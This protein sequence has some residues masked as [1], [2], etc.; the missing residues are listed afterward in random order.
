MSDIQEYKFFGELGY[1]LAET[2]VGMQQNMNREQKYKIYT[3]TG[4]DSIMKLALPDH[5]IEYHI[6]DSIDEQRSGWFSPTGSK[7]DMRELYSIA[8]N[9]NDIFNKVHKYISKPL[10][11]SNDYLTELTRSYDKI[12]MVFLRDRNWETYRNY[13]N[14]YEIVLN[15]HKKTLLVFSNTIE[16]IVP[17][18]PG[19]TE[20]YKTKSLLENIYFFNICDVFISSNSGMITLAQNSACK[21][22]LCLFDQ[23]HVHYTFNPF[24]TV[25]GVYSTDKLADIINE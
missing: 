25:I 20:T 19:N 3:F 8:G 2:L 4:F 7:Y 21:K 5:N 13:D 10:T 6:V 9:V 12:I 18:A 17:T 16:S 15:T 11:Y 23:E 14:K 22:I 24:N 1:L